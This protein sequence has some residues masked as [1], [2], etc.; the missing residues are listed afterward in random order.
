MA[1]R[2]LGNGQY[3]GDQSVDV[4]AVHLRSIREK[5]SQNYSFYP[6]FTDL[7]Y[8]LIGC[9]QTHQIA[10]EEPKLLAGFPSHILSLEKNYAPNEA[11]AFKKEW[12]DL[13]DK[14]IAVYQKEWN[15]NPSMQEII[16]NFSYVLVALP[17]GSFSDVNEGELIYLAIQ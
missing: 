10:F 11:N 1:W 2:D 16:A 9:S 8:A 17:Q 6:F 12:D 4:V 13:F 3:R 5:H 14:L 15:R 7:F